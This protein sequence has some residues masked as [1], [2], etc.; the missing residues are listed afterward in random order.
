MQN[1]NSSL[2]T[3]AVKNIPLNRAYLPVP[4]LKKTLLLFLLL[5]CIHIRVQS[6]QPAVEI[7]FLAGPAFTSLYGNPYIET[8]LEGDQGF[9]AGPA[10]YYPFHR[11]WAI[12]SNLF[13]EKKGA[14][15]LMPYFD[16]EGELVGIFQTDVGY[17]Y[18]TAPLLFD[19][20]FG[21]RLSGH[22]TGGAYTGLMLGQSTRYSD[23]VSGE[24]FNENSTSYYRPWDS[25]LV[26][27]FGGR[28]KLKPRWSLS[29]ETRF[30]F[31]ISNIVSRPVL[32]SLTIYNNATQV[33]F[34]VYYTPGYIFTKIRG[35]K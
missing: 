18:I 19:Y 7:G 30:N 15:G 32:G 14:S 17:R 34:G 24:S 4:A 16:N 20:Y 10:F 31:G 13:F 28:Y 33:L 9:A 8:F 2:V 27:G 35:V 11:R 29:L 25:G 6:Q 12:R 23:P 5:L 1:K 22:L 3:H 26:L 21:R